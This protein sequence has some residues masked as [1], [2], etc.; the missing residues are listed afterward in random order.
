MSDKMEFRPFPLDERDRQEHLAKD[1]HAIF[2]SVAKDNRGDRFNENQVVWHT[3]LELE[4]LYQ[5]TKRDH[6][7][8][9]LE[10]H[11]VPLGAFCGGS[12]VS[13]ILRED[14]RKIS[15]VKCPAVERFK[16]LDAVTRTKFD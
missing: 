9:R 1:I 4:A 2:G 15:Q 8:E 13:A 7:A 10:G 12:A 16:E 5:L 3:V 6:D 14:G 11:V